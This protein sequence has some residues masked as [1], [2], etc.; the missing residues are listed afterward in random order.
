MS[1]WH[2]IL[3]GAPEG[4]IFHGGKNSEWLL[5]DPQRR[6]RF[7]HEGDTIIPGCCERWRHL[8]REQ[9]QTSGSEVANLPADNEDELPWQVT[10][11][12]EPFTTAATL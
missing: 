11:C 6:D 10:H 1:G 5:I 8:H 4:V 7:G 12:K 3:L 2:M 9:V